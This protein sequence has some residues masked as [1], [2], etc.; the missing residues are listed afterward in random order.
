MQPCKTLGAC[1]RY[2]SVLQR[3]RLLAPCNMVLQE[4][5]PKPKLKPYVWRAAEVHVLDKA[6]DAATYAEADYRR[7]AAFQGA[8][9]SLGRRDAPLARAVYENSDCY[10]GPYS[11]DARHGKGVYLHANKGAFAGALR[12]RLCRNALTWWCPPGKPCAG[13]VPAAWL[14][15]L[16]QCGG[17]WHLGAG[18]MTVLRWHALQWPGGPY[19][20][21]SAVACPR[22]PA[23]TALTHTS[24][25][26]G[27]HP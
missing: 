9:N 20:L 10:I 8:Y 5:V 15:S 25:V 7:T 2:S 17:L 24:A 19:P 23:R 22:P 12:P 6:E 26:P 3:H 14:T 4:D 21:E 13:A 18:C 11:E 16:A 27:E 1:T